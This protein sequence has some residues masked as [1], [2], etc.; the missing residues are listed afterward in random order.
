M[1]PIWII[2]K[3]ELDV[4]ELPMAYIIIILFPECVLHGYKVQTFCKPP[5]NLLRI[6]H[7]FSFIPVS[8]VRMIRRK[9]TGTIECYL[10]NPLKKK[11]LLQGNCCHI[12]PYQETL[13]LTLGYYITVA[14][15]EKLT[16]WFTGYFGLIF[17]ECSLYK[18]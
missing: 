8:L 6:A 3:R 11:R 12:A 18:H 2:A 1:K 14:N 10:P 15:P 16:K 9:K 4:F 17:Y 13:V 5:L 7:T